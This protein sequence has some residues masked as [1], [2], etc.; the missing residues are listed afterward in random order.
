MAKWY[1]ARFGGNFADLERFITEV[2]KEKAA[3][4]EKFLSQSIGEYEPDIQG[5][6]GRIP[7]LRRF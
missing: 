3:D 1:V 4:E 2:L 5:L 6:L 7:I